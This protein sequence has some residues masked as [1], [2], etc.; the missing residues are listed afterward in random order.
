MAVGIQHDVAEPHLARAHHVRGRRD[1]V[2]VAVAH[3]L[4]H[5]DGRVPDHDPLEIARARRHG[6]VA[7]QIDPDRPCAVLQEHAQGPGQQL[8]AQR[9]TE[10]A[11]V[12]LADRDDH[13]ARV[14]HARARVRQALEPV[15]EVQLEG[16][17]DPDLTGR[18]QRAPHGEAERGGRDRS[19]QAAEDLPRR[20][21]ASGRGQR[22][23]PE[24]CSSPTCHDADISLV[25]EHLVA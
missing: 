20:H 15:V 12:L 2:D 9:V 19:T 7:I 13:D 25:P 21:V 10:A 5:H 24:G 11:D 14:G 6:A 22:T 3:P 4:G 8:V 17:E 18:N 23:P 16:L 1:R